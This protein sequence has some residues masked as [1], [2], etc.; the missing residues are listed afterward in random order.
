MRDAVR[1]VPRRELVLLAA[2]VVLG[3]IIRIA[4][5]ISFRHHA[6]AGD[7]ISYDIDAKLWAL[8]HPFWSTSPF[9]IPH[10]SMWKA[11]GY[12]AWAGVLYDIGG[13]KY[14]RVE[15]AQVVLIGPLTIVLV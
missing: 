1:A 13:S 2:A 4:F 5:L 10:D 11:P 9:G 8:G 12:T 14:H 6:L 3:L 7:E 15:A